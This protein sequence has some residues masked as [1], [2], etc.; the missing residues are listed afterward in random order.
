[1]QDPTASRRRHLG[2][3]GAEN[4]RDIGGYET[5]DGRRVAWGRVYRSGHLGRLTSADVAEIAKLGIRMVCDLRATSERADMES[6]LPLGEPPKVITLPVDFPALEPGLVRRRL[7]GRHFAPGALA[8]TV[9]AAYR[10]YVTDFAEAFGGVLAALA[11]PGHVP[12]L[13]HCNGGKD[14]TGFAAALVLLALGVP[15]TTILAD[16]LLTNDLTRWTTRRRTWVVFLAS[17]L[18]MRPREMRALLEAREPYLEAAFATMEAR[19]G[20]I[21]A[22]LREALGLTDDMRARLRAALLE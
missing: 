13:I 9:L 17:R 4:F 21:D 22:Y 7:L 6:R 11:D 12:A 16:Y 20:S 8:E 18:S 3:D 1:M 10:A 5:S 19:H 2:L 14:R 15:R